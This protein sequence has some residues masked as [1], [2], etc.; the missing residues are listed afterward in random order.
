MTT[1][2]LKH[3]N[4][5]ED[6]CYPI[7]LT[8]TLKSL[9]Y[10]P[11]DIC[12]PFHSMLHV[13]CFRF[14]FWLF[15]PPLSFSFSSFG[16]ASIPWPLPLAT[17]ILIHCKAA[18]VV[19]LLSGLSAL[20]RSKSGCGFSGRDLLW[21][22]FTAALLASGPE[23]RQHSVFPRKQMKRCMKSLYPLLGIW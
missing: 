7:L 12:L 6:S 1:T 10:C 11:I 21:L 4:M 13:G 3:Y 5:A 8:V 9:R 14:L 20:R 18:T 19:C 15:F 17:P 2:I 22:F 16:S 23:A